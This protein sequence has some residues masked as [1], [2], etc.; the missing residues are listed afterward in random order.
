MLASAQVFFTSMRVSIFSV[1]LFFLIIAA[2]Q[3]LG[4]RDIRAYYFPA[5]ELYKGQVYQYAL[6]QN[7]STADEYWYYR[8]TLR[9]S[10]LFLTATNYDRY[11]Q[12]DQITTEK[13][14][15]S[16]AV[17]RDYYVYEPDTVTGKA[18]QA[19]AVVESPNVFPFQV[20]DSLG[21]FLFRLHYAP[22]NDTA[23]KIYVIRNRRFLGDAPDFE[24]QGRKYACIRFGIKEV[25][26]NEK[27]GASE[28]EG[29]G[30]EWYAQ[31]IGLVYSRKD[32]GDYHLESRLINRFPMQELEKR[33]GKHFGQE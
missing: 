20:T 30:E 19:R 23:T 18:K 13:L 5:K 3:N 21:V 2:C 25:V 9:D 31:G 11:F 17:S 27:E 4:K 28:V 24:L 8:S 22:A 16:G 1:L 6:T 12:I 10:G 7:G 26:G 33:A 32:F 29:Q 14:F 15:E